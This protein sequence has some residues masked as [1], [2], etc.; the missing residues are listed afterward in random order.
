VICR[1]RASAYAEGARAGAPD[2]VQVA[3][4]FHL[5]QNLA[6]AVE[7]LVAKHKSCLVEQPIAAAAAA[8]A[9][10]VVEEPQGAMAQRRRSHHALVHEMLARG[11]GFRQI[12]RHLVLQPGIVI[13]AR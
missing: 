4:R 3:D 11:A 5:W 9:V 2:A 13:T 12:A 7:R 10:Q 8:A 6:T 1:D